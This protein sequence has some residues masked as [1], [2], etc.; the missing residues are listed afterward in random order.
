MRVNSCTTNV[1]R[2][3]VPVMAKVTP[4]LVST[5]IQHGL[6]VWSSDRR[7]MSWVRRWAARGRRWC[8]HTARACASSPRTPSCQTSLAESSNWLLLIHCLL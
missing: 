4:G 5:I 3:A 7:R 2:S 6:R 1:G 8:G